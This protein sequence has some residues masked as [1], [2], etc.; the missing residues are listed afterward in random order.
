VPNNSRR[1]QSP[2]VRIHA[3]A[4][5]LST[6]L[7]RLYRVVVALRLMSTSQTRR[8]QKT[9]IL[10]SGYVKSGVTVIAPGP[11][12]NACACSNYLS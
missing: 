1:H 6:Q 5:T 11:K 8:V 2:M 9:A 4:A 3:N 10:P 12:A 7:D